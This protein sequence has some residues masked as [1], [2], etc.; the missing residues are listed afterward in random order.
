MVAWS[1]DKAVELYDWVH[2]RGLQKPETVDLDLVFL[3]GQTPHNQMSSLRP[4]ARM[5]APIGFAAEDSNASGFPGFS[6]WRNILVNELNVCE[7]RIVPIKGVFIRKNTA[8]QLVAHTGDDMRAFVIHAKEHSLRDVASLQPDLHTLRCFMTAVRWVQQ[9]GAKNLRIHPLIGD[10][11]SWDE[12]A[13][14]SQGKQSGRR[15]DMVF[16][17]AAKLHPLWEREQIASPHECFEY[18]E[19][20]G[21]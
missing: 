11:L 1:W 5:H 8:G 19:R 7:S 15:V 14:H 2:E 9:L 12:Y 17:E 21:L 20:M 18:I 6:V 3:P 13:L 16:Y 4:S 10:D